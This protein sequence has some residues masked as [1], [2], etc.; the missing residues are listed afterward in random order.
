MNAINPKA[1]FI[2]LM[3]EIAKESRSQLPQPWFKWASTTALA[4]FA[5]NGAT[6]EE[7]K[8]VR[9]FLET[10]V[11]I[12]ETVPEPTRLPIKTLENS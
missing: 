9:R 2:E 4:Q 6:A 10:L 3:P 12:A 7:L 11:N 1:D 8:G 5:H